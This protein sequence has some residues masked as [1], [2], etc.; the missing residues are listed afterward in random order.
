MSQ[1]TAPEGAGALV[2][3]G[4]GGDVPDDEFAGFGDGEDGPD[5]EALAELAA[6]EAAERAAEAARA[7]EYLQLRREAD[8]AHRALED[9]R[10]AT[11]EAVR[12]YREAVLAAEP[13]LP[14]ELV[15]GETLA[16][17]EAA[18]GT[19]RATVARVRDRLAR[20][21]EAGAAAGTMSGAA[22]AAA[23]FPVGAPGR[24]APSTAGLDG[25]GKIARGLRER[26]ERGR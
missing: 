18:L 11:R 25:A 15:G 16:E 23:G 9:E 10:A 14:A 7:A 26:A 22:G 1:D 24:R 5:A 2:D 6:V 13:D 8:E 3:R 17:V 21:G 4:G 12:R 20:A 19:A